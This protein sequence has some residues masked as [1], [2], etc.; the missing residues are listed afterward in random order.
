VHVAEVQLA[1]DSVGICGTDV[2]FWQDGG[3]GD[4]Q[5]KDPVVLGHEPSGTVTKVGEGVKHLKVGTFEEWP[6]YYK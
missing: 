6:Y 1:I 3:M 2:H 4:F 5:V